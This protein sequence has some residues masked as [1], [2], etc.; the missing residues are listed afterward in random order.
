MKTEIVTHING[1]PIF[2]RNIPILPANQ[3]LR[4]RARALR[5]A[6]VLSEVIFWRQVRARSFWNI[7][8]D[9]QRI[10]GNF[11][12]DFYVKSLGLIIEVDGSS[13][14]DNEDYDAMR[15]EFL[16]NQGLNVYRI[17]DFRVKQDL[18]NVMKELENYIIAN[19]GVS[20]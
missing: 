6:G 7:D 10:I 14:N 20:E 12:V 8:F 2:R 1:N 19:Y 17:S 15:E 18:D 3:A 5:K 16:I 13:H 9:R 4:S 11:I